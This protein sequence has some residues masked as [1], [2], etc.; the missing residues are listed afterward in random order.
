MT[1]FSLLRFATLLLFGSVMVPLGAMEPDHKRTVGKATDAGLVGQEFPPGADGTTGAAPVVLVP[2][3]QVQTTPSV[4]AWSWFSRARVT[5]RLGHSLLERAVSGHGR[6]VAVDYRLQPGDLLRVVAWGGVQVNTLLPVDAQ[7]NLGLPEHGVVPVAG[8]MVGEVQAIV[9]DLLRSHFKSAGAVV[10]VERATMTAVVVT[11]EVSRPGTVLVPAGGT[12]VEALSLCGPV[13]PQGSLR[14]VSVSVP[15]AATNTIDLYRVL[16]DGDLGGLKQLSPGS[17]IHVPLAGPQVSIFGA[18]RRVPRTAVPEEKPPLI[19]KEDK[20]AV[21]NQSLRIQAMA[22]DPDAFVGLQV[23]MLPGEDLATALRLAGGPT[24][25]ADRS[26]VRILRETADGQRLEQRSVAQLSALAAADGDRMLLVPQALIPQQTKTLQVEGAVRTPGLYGWSEGATLERLLAIAG[27]AAPNADLANTTIRRR[28]TTPQAVAVSPG[29]T[30]EAF[31][32]V[33]SAKA[34]DTVLQPGDVVMIPV[35]PPLDQQQLFVSVEGAVMHPGRL[36]LAPGMHVRDM[37]ALAG[38]LDPDAHLESADLVRTRIDGKGAVTVERVVVDLKPIIQG[39][40]GP[41]LDNRDVLVVRRRAEDR[42]RVKVSGEVLT[43]GELVLP[44]GTSLRTVLTLS[45]GF[46]SQAFPEGGMLL[47]ASEKAAQEEHLREMARRLKT[48]VGINERRVV[49]ADSETDRKALEA[50]IANQ[51]DELVR[52]QTAAATGRLSGVRFSDAFAG[53]EGS[54]LALSDGDS[55][56]VPARPNSIR[57]LGEVMAPGSVVYVPGMRSADVVAR[58]GGYSRQ[59]DTEMVFV[60]R[61]DGSVVATE[62]RRGSAWDSQTRRYARTTIRTLVL[63]EGDTVVI[64][65]DLTFQPNGM[66]QL[67]DWST[68]VFQLATAA[69]TLA[70]LSQ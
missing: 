49:G 42:I 68:V 20:V 60:V 53:I 47:R 9:V 46:T 36:P 39:E 57:I 55:I 41:A 43:P 33:L 1:M 61:A 16:L 45:G 14:T 37:L 35:R 64:P 23:E 10:S 52:M 69:G 29:L 70:V 34:L 4:N 44:V 6:A 28:L 51:Q 40:S 18:A 67:K 13:L 24:I 2:T 32:S 12:V 26:A 48:S 17:I 21:V 63:A 22:Q 27:G 11:G 19:A 66:T 58:C 65:P 8:K 15:G 50:T 31:E 54:D 38:G 3:A 62:G 30:A 56:I 59:A 7:G 25:E 5:V